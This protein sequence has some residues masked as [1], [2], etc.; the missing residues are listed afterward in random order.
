[1]IRAWSPPVK[2]TPVALARPS[3]AS[4]SRSPSSGTAFPFSSSVAWGPQAAS[5]GACGASS[6]R[7]ASQ[8][9]FGSPLA[10]GITRTR[11]DA[12][13]AH[14]TKRRGPRRTISPADDHQAG[15]GRA[16][17][18]GRA[19]ST[20]PGAGR[21]LV[22]SRAVLHVCGPASASAGRGARAGLQARAAEWPTRPMKPSL[23]VHGGCGTP[24]PGEEAARNAACERAADAGWG[25][26]QP[27]GSALDAAEAA[28][29][30]LEDEP[31]LNAGTG[32]Y[33]QA[34]GV[35]RLD[36]S[37]MADDGRAGAVAQVPLLPHPVSLARYLLEQDAHVML[38][39]PEAL[40]LAARLGHEVGVVATPAKIAY[41]QEHLDETCRRLDYA[42]MAA[43]WK[44]ENPRLGTV[45]CVALDARGR[46][47][48]AT[49]TGG[50][51]QCYP[52]RVGDTPIIGAGTYCT[53]R[54]GVSMTGRR[55][56]HPREAGRQ[57]PGRPGG[58]RRRRSPTP[59]A[60]CS[61]R[62]ARGPASS[63]STA[64]ARPSSCAT[65][66]SWR[67]RGGPRSPAR[68]HGLRL[69]HPAPPERRRIS[70]RRGGTPRPSTSCGRRSRTTRRRWPSASASPTCS[71]S[72]T[73]ADEALPILLGAADELARYGFAD[74]ALEALRRADAIAPGHAEV[75]DRFE[76]LV[77]GGAGPDRGGGGREPPPEEKTDPARGGRRA[78]G[79]RPT[80]AGGRRRGAASRQG[81]ARLRARPRGPAGGPGPR[82]P[83]PR[84]SSPRS[85]TTSSG[86]PRRASTG[87]SCPAGGIVVTEGDP[88]RHRLP[89]RERQRA[90]PRAGR[91]RARPRDPPARR[92]RL[93]RRGGGALGAA[94]H[95]HRRRR[96]PTASCWRSTTGRSSGSSR[97]GP[98]PGPSS[99]APATA[100]RESAGGERGPLAAGGRRARSGRP[101][102]SPRTS[103]APTWSPRVRLHFAK[104]MLDAGHE[105]D[106]LAVDRER[107]R[108]AGRRAA[109]PRPASRILK[110]VDQARKRDDRG[111]GA[112]PCRARRPRPPSASGWARSPRARTR[113]C[114]RPRPPR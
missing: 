60:G 55:R 19:A 56:A 113:Y 29:R 76:T 10:Q 2:K 64:T 39:G 107:G 47:A 32:A 104:Q 42:A 59:R 99:R 48:A 38:A 72:P 83:R 58:R 110:K 69:A 95:G 18:R 31:L 73:G 74:R 30:A 50:T 40:T 20:R 34:D 65:R 9:S 79:A 78:E 24:P 12:P 44:A 106:A 105:K 94:A 13:P 66:P 36:A 89:D 27:G 23:I 16:Q 102:S 75:R 81:A 15:L 114:A 103:A 21:A 45:G 61:T 70:S 91:A 41:W 25:V 87:G 88:G 52:G 67:R 100:A 63:P 35:A 14:S 71:S 46:L 101:P 98:P 4:R 111:D 33:L 96:P 6:S 93:L 11:A 22:G 51:G 109:T 68:A 57:A 112:R 62:S 85:R 84:R 80:A 1:M 17:P 54:V 7:S 8:L 53:P 28:V 77:P 90:H 3:I 86:A 26:L 97:P 92:G 108:G 37:I 49:S 43:A 5:P 82:G